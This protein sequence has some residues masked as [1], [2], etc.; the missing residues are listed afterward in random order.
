MA[1]KQLHT[2]IRDN[3]LSE[4]VA[5]CDAGQL[6]VAVCEGQPADYSDV[7]LLK[8]G[9]GTRLSDIQAYA[10]A[11]DTLQN[12]GVETGIF[13]GREVVLAA[14]A[15]VNVAEDS[16]ASPDLVAAIIDTTNSLLLAVVEE[17]SDQAL[18]AGNTVDIP[19]ITLRLPS[20]VT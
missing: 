20:A 12:I 1:T 2:N 13:A 17:T 7:N 9:G 18:T 16:V 5:A 6:A 8:S 15:G 4:V 14:K 10:A 3:G 19:A 11:D